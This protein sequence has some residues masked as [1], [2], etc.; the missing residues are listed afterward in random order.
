MSDNE[1][2]YCGEYNPDNFSTVI[3]ELPVDVIESVENLSYLIPE[4]NINGA[5]ALVLRKGIKAIK[6]TPLPINNP[7][8]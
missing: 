7:N 2:D 6:T 8:I 3:I 4:G 5:Y 1:Q